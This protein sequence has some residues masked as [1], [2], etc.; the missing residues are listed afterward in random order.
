MS[1]HI[2]EPTAIR[3]SGERHLIHESIGAVALQHCKK[4]QHASN[5]AE[6]RHTISPSHR[7]SVNQMARLAGLTRASLPGKPSHPASDPNQ[8][9]GSAIDA[10][11]RASGMSFHVQPEHLRQANKRPTSSSSWKAFF[12]IL[13]RSLCAGPNITSESN[14]V[15][16]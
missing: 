15:Q 13:G 7:V 10:G 9:L 6:R 5:E 2:F 8:I 12:S 4:A 1:H 11:R 14:I 16:W 3:K